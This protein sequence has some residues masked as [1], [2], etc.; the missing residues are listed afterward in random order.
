V[1]K[2]KKTGLL[3]SIYERPDVRELIGQADYI[4]KLDDDDVISPV[5]LERL[6]D[7][8]GDLYYDGSHT[9]FDITSG[10]VT[11][12]SR[13]WVASTCV[14][15]KA[16][17]FDTWHGEGASE[18]GNLLYS[19]HSKSWHVYYSTKNKVAAD[20]S[21]PVY[22]RVLSPTSIT[23][24]G[25]MQFSASALNRYHE[26]L[27]SFGNWKKADVLAFEEYMPQLRAA[28]KKYSGRD[29]SDIP[30]RTS[31]FRILSKLFSA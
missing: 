15:R 29:W 25:G 9:F 12:Q 17:A 5:I 21:E 20:P 7:F 1:E 10:T 14:H 27:A 23:G 8:H 30:I 19:D 28:W 2:E 18:L 22:M 13:P 3:R 4:I 24:G 6:K 11:Q 26:Y 16:C 31:L